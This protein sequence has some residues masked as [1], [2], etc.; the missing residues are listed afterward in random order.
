MPPQM[1][2][3]SCSSS[4]TIYVVWLPLKYRNNRPFK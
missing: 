1:L 3:F 2:H 4:A